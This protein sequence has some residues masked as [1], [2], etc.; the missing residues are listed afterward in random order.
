MNIYQSPTTQSK[1]Q[2]YCSCIHCKLE[3][4]IQN[5]ERHYNS[6]HTFKSNCLQCSLPLISKNKF[7][8]TSCAATYNN[9]KRDYST[10]RPGPK[11]GYI[12]R[13]KKP[14]Y[15]KVS[16]CIVC[17]KL[18]PRSGKTCSDN[19]Y[20]TLIS[21]KM[22]QVISDGYDP[23]KNRGRGKKS[24]LEISFESWLNQHFPDMGYI[25]EYPI[26]RLD[27]VKT[28]FGD[29]YFPEL[30]LIIELDGTQHDNTKDYDQD[31]DAY[32]TETYGIRVFRITHKEYVSKTKLDIVVQLLTN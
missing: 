10:F 13:S 32:I 24:Y 1:F 11:K 12:T 28:Y 3:V 2:V 31:R 8:S 18:H 17:S 30:N 23:K 14:P 20:K 25:P 27:V 5:I 22:K 16:C 19:C 15:T 9:S 29:F 26:K 4:S 7:C 21:L 6:K